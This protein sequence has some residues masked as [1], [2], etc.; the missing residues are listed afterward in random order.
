MATVKWYSPMITHEVR[1]IR[2]RSNWWTNIERKLF[3]EKVKAL[4]TGQNLRYTKKSGNHI[5]CTFS[6]L[7]GWIKHESGT[8]L[9]RYKPKVS[10]YTIKRH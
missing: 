1:D 5:D 9:N 7:K 2:N 3:R 10:N 6:C 8:R 4:K